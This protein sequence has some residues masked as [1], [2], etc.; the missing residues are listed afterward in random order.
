MAVII[1]I[2][3]GKREDVKH[4]TAVIGREI[5]RLCGWLA[6]RKKLRGQEALN[7]GDEKILIAEGTHVEETPEGTEHVAQRRTKNLK[8]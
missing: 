2:I 5:G 3:L 8:Y 4:S 7:E 6:Q 1:S